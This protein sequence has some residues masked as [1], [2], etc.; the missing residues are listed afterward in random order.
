MLREH[1]ERELE[2]R[3]LRDQVELSWQS[4]FGRCKHG[5][6]TLVREIRNPSAAERRF[7]LATMPPPRGSRAILYNHVTPPDVAEI[8]REHLEG[9]RPVRRLVRRM[10]TS[11]RRTTASARPPGKSEPTGTDGESQG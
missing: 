1:F 3:D 11:M 7:V 5:P 4:C 2:K 10:A 6:N 9:G 8:V